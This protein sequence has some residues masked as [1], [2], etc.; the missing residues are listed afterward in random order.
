M[1]LYTLLKRM[2]FQEMRAAFDSQDVSQLQKVASEMDKELFA[3][4]LQRCIDSGL[5]VPDANKDKAEA[6]EQ[7]D[8]QAEYQQVGDATETPEPKKDR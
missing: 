8:D 6:A 3:H 2:N 5:W 7:G 1:H 4:H